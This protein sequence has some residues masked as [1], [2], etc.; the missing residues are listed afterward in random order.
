MPDWP[1]AVPRL[2]RCSDQGQLRPPVLEQFEQVVAGR[3][4]V[5]LRIDLFHAP[6]LEA[7][8]APGPFELSVDRLDDGLTQGIDRLAVFGSEF[9]G[10][11]DP[12]HAVLRTAQ[13]IGQFTAAFALAVALVLPGIQ[14]LGP[15][16]QG[17]DPLLQLLFGP[18]HPLVAHGFVLEALALTLVTSTAT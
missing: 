13:S 5:P 8:Q 9:A 4:Q 1:I 2:S 14:D 18:E 16:H 15:A 10:L 6:E 7:A 17:V 12:G 3:D 11:A